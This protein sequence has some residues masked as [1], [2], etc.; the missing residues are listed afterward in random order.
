[1]WPDHLGG[2]ANA[3]FNDHPLH[4]HQLYSSYNRVLHSLKL[5]EYALKHCGIAWNQPKLL[6]ASKVFVS[7]F[8]F[9]FVFVVCCGMLGG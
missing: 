2:G 3:R 5:T 9:I 4:R 7:V 8:L 1:M 6:L